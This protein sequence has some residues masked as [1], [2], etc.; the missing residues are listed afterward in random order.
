MTIATIR[1]FIGADF[2]SNSLG[3]FVTPIVPF[4][5]GLIAASV[6]G[7][8]I[9]ESLAPIAGGSPFEIASGTASV[10]SKDMAMS[11]V[12]RLN[13]S[14]TVAGNMTIMS[15]INATTVARD[16]IIGGGLGVT[17]YQM[18]GQTTTGKVNAI[19]QVN[20]VAQSV[21]ITLDARE[22]EFIAA[23]FNKDAG[24]MA[25]YIPRTGN[26]Q[27]ISVTAPAST[28]AAY[29]ICSYS[30]SGSAVYAGPNTQAFHS[31]NSVAVSRTDIDAVYASVKAFVATRGVA[32]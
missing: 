3:K 31:V 1:T 29:R 27:Q 16:T 12:V 19:T 6:F 21:E 11:G 22:Y 23:I 28:G 2:S 26:L 17:S 7:G 24:T 15:V 8:S 14:T 13:P 4:P 9:A 20:S 18:M 25:L 30:T 32:I 5:T 10:S